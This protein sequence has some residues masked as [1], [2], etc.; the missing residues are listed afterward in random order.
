MKRT[1]E[2][3]EIQNEWEQKAA[4]M[5]PHRLYRGPA[6]WIG[7]MAILPPEERTIW[8]ELLHS[9]KAGGYTIPVLAE[10]WADGRR[11]ALEIV[12]LVEM[13]TG[14]RDAE[15]IVRR[16]ELLQMLGLVEL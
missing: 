16:F 2:T 5:R 11:T 13:E 1:I 10:Y 8:Y 4:E 14:L 15:L 7:S 9:R 3:T 12:D 6:S